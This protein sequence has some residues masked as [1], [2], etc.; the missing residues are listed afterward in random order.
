MWLPP[1]LHRMVISTARRRIEYPPRKNVLAREMKWRIA[2][3]ICSATL[4][5]VCVCCVPV[6][7]ILFV[8]SLTLLPFTIPLVGTPD[9]SDGLL[10]SPVLLSFRWK[11]DEQSP[12]PP[13]PPAF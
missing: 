2:D 11:L 8:V 6:V 3:S 7:L 13:S 1:L 10:R 9:S 12:P 4:Y 5:S